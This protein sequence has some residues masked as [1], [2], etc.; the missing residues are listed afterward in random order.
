MTEQQRVTEVR[1]DVFLH[2]LR[3]VLQVK[4]LHVVEWYEKMISNCGLFQYTIPVFHQ[5]KLRENHDK[6][7]S[8]RN[9]HNPNEIQKRYLEARLDIS[10]AMKIQVAVFWVMTPCS[11]VAGYLW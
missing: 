1:N 3:M 4:K 9:A 5:E 11:D 6:F 10:M 2:Y 8:V 7:H